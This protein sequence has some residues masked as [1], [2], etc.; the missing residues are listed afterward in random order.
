MEST[1]RRA[2]RPRQALL[3]TQV[4]HR[5]AL[6]LID[7]EGPD[8]F[9]LV[10]LAR[11]MGVRMPSLYNHVNSREEVVQG[12]RELIAAEVDASSMGR[13]PW[14]LALEAWARSY[15]Q[16]FARHP[17]TVKLLAVTPVSSLVVLDEYETIV[18]ALEAS[19]WP[20]G[21]ALGVLTALESFILGSVLD[22]SAPEKMIDLPDGSPSHPRLSAALEESPREGRA[23]LAFDIGLRALIG[24][25]R[26][27]LAE[28]GAAPVASPPQP[29][30]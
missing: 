10:R 9:S 19:G 30:R 3:S 6:D 26:L 28:A 17:N 2:G 5:T 29:A 4:I 11:E 1:P 21:Q 15:R 27:E 7:R 16:A 18:T 20:T 13:L 25:L 22:L 8:A 23:N 14:D 12:V 24:G